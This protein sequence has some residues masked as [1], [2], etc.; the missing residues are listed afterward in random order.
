MS[1]WV[2]SG[3]YQSPLGRL[4]PALPARSAKVFVVNGQHGRAADCGE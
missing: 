3:H 2:K 4:E 1:A